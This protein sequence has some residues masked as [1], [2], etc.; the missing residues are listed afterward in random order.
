MYKRQ[1][2][3]DAD[4]IL[5]KFYTTPIIYAHKML[6]STVSALKAGRDIFS[7][8]MCIRDRPRMA[9]QAYMPALQGAG[10][11]AVSYTHLFGLI[12][13]SIDKIEVTERLKQIILWGAF[14]SIVTYL[15]FSQKMC[16]RDSI[17]GNARRCIIGKK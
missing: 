3:D 15:L 11:K 2:N 6:I 4:E 17:L 10:H 9:L 13:Y 14:L 7:P 16:I 1:L 12:I 5:N 8:Q